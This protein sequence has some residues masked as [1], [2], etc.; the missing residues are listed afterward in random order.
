MDLLSA[1]AV[2]VVNLVVTG[3]W[4]GSVLFLP[5]YKFG[6]DMVGCLVSQAPVGAP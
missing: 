2:S 3:T 1:W 4:F 5:W 6:S